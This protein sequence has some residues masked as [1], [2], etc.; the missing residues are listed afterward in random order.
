[1]S[2][3]KKRKRY[4]SKINLNLTMFTRDQLVWCLMVTD[5]RISSLLGSHLIKL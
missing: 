3:R 5:P 2:R 4:N 1:M